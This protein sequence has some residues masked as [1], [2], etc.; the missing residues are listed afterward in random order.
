MECDFFGNFLL[1]H[2][3]IHADGDKWADRG[4]SA[5]PFQGRPDRGEALRATSPVGLTRRGRPT[6]ALR[7]RCDGAGFLREFSSASRNHSRRWRQVGGP[8]RVSPTIL[9]SA[10]VQEALLP[11]SKKATRSGDRMAF[12][13]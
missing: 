13:F 10:G 2:V 5:L 11:I 9:R 3:T 6:L 8:R 1:R 4:G 7:A 12:Y